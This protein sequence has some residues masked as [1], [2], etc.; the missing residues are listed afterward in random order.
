M[1]STQMNN[2]AEALNE[3]A[4][5]LEKLGREHMAVFEALGVRYPL[6]DELGGFAGMLRDMCE[7]TPLGGEALGFGKPDFPDWCKTFRERAAYQHGVADA[8]RLINEPSEIGAHVRTPGYLPP[9]PDDMNDKRADWASSAVKRFQELT[10]TDDETAIGDLLSDLMHL[11][12]R[13]GEN[14]E[15]LLRKGRDHY[16]EETLPDESDAKSV[17]DECGAEVEDVMSCPDGAVICMDCFNA[18]KH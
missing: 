5:A 7:S 15:E 11:C 10:R 1:N 18:G 8:R 2:C 6:A 4:D 12:D 16:R 9:D 13:S 14:F 3:A 17:C